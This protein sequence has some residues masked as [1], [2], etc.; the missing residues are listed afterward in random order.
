MN[1]YSPTNITAFCNTDDDVI[2]RFTW[3]GNSWTEQEDIFTNP[4]SRRLCWAAIPGNYGN[5]SHAEA[6]VIFTEY[7]GGPWYDVKAWAWGSNGILNFTAPKYAKFY[8]TIPGNLSDS[9]YLVYVYYGN[10][11]VSSASQT[12]R[13]EFRE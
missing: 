1:I 12:V 8:V 2:T 10:T 7:G 11:T 3:D 6:Q 9:D 13:M 5:E 4:S